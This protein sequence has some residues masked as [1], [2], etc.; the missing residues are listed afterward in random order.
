MLKKSII[1]LSLVTAFAANAQQASAPTTAASTPAKKELVAR[2]LKVQQPGI[3]AMARRLVEA[4]AAELMGSAGAALAQRIPKE[5]QEAVAKEIQG[6]IHK[7]LEDA[8]PV[9]QK[10]AVAL[11]PSTVG[12]MLEERFTEDELKQIATMLEAPAFAKFQRMGDDMQQ[13]LGEKLVADTRSAIEPKVRNLEQSV[14]K[15]LG[16]TPSAPAPA[17]A[18]S[19]GGSNAKP[20]AKK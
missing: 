14:A 19:N 15:R 11:A 10:R 7:Y 5:K 18:A 17:A 12:A 9:V 16:V 3:E 2:I 13:A 20:P 1:T 6:D 4:P 8:V